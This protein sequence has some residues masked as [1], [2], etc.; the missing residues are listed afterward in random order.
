MA[1]TN[2]TLYS[3]TPSSNTDINN[4]NIDEN[5]PASGLNNAIRELM[6]HLKN[7]DTGSQALTALSVTGNATVNDGIT[8]TDSGASPIIANRTTSDGT[9]IDFRKDGTQVGNIETQGS[10]LIINATSNNLQLLRDTTGS[11]RGIN[12][13]I[14]HFKPFDSNDAQIDLGT[15]SGRFK[16]LYLSGGAYIGGTGSANLLDDYEE[17]TFTPIWS[18]AGAPTFSAQI[19]R[20]TKIGNRVI[21]NLYLIISNKNTMTGTQKVS[22]LPFTSENTS[23]NYNA[24]SIWM[25]A[26]DSTGVFNG[27]QSRQAFQVPNTT[28]IQIYAGNGSGGV[29]QLDTSHMTNTTDIM[30]TVSYNVA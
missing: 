27:N 28:N 20:Y 13:G 15:S 18:G 22:G 1:K 11:S 4:I 12:F 3:S 25:G 19:G 17:G 8:V 23:N 21:A 9:I 5:C 26:M 6:A 24:C 2:I 14:D 10:A 16:D 29:T 7:V 30:L